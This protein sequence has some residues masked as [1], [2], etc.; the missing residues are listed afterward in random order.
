M[1]TGRPL[2][3]RERAALAAV[4]DAFH[5]ALTPEDGDDPAL[6]AI[7]A[8]T[9]G[10]PRAAEEAIHS[11]GLKERKALV[12]LLRLLAGPLPGLLIGRPRALA[13]MDAATRERLL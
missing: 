8:T 9:V 11:L 12:S 3:D 10:V 6:F 4:C 13:R 2:S 1:T 5:P 7:A